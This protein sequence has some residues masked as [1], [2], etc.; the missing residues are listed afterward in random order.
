MA[1]L[2]A[3]DPHF[4][5]FGTKPTAEDL[6]AKGPSGGSAQPVSP[7]FEF[8]GSQGYYGPPGNFAARG[9]GADPGPLRGLMRKPAPKVPSALLAGHD[10]TRP[11]DRE[12]PADYI[13]DV[14]M[15]G[16]FFSPFQP[17]MP[18]GPPNVNFPRTWDYNVGINL[19]IYPRQVQVFAML[20]ALAESWGIVAVEMQARIDELIGL[21]WKFALK[22]DSKSANK[23]SEDD[24]RIQDITEFFKVPD[25]KQ[26]YAMWMRSIFVDR[27][28][29]DA[30]SAFIWKNR[31]GNKPYAILALDGATVKP[32][33]D[34]FGRIPDFPQP[35]YQQIIKGLPMDNYTERELVYMPARPRTNFPIG[36]YSEVMQIVNEVMQGVKKTIYMGNFWK[37]GTLPDVMLGVPEAWTPDQIAI[38]Q[39]S[40]DALLSGNLNLK[41]KIRFIPGGMKPFEMKGSAGELLKSD[42]DVWIARIVCRAFR[43]LPKSYVPEPASRASVES[44]KEQLDLQGISVEKIWWKGFMDRLIMLGWDYSDI[45]LSWDDDQDVDVVNQQTVLSGYVK[46]AEMTINESRAIRGQDP[47]EGGDVPLI[48]TAGGAIPLSVIAKQ[49]EMPQK[50]APS[51]G[52]GDDGAKPAGG[53]GAGKVADAPF[54]KRTE[55]GTGIRWK[56]Y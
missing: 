42:Y 44:E 48:F 7:G 20:R 31:L 4:T 33:V 51:A 29:I 38:W 10:D 17:V 24:P 1:E 27:Y 43:T 28:T 46:T 40:F 54:G 55:S 3:Q 25:R 56:K 32:L 19:D 37:E 34:D 23:K 6:F 47:V 15:S 18:F 39:A 5:G 49:T 53:K 12:N 30:A 2:D 22:K 41:S 14:D 50:A 21:P 16:N 36:G 8:T 11:T 26:P 45:E 13:E 35:A 52:G 9:R